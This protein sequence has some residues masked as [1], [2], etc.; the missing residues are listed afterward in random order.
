MIRWQ[1]T[2]TSSATHADV[3]SHEVEVT[4]QTA[5]SAKSARQQHT[6]S[7]KVQEH[8]I[9]NLMPGTQYQVSNV[10]CN[11]PSPKSVKNCLLSSVR[12]QLSKY[13]GNVYIPIEISMGMLLAACNVC[14][15]YMHRL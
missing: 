3:A 15:P 5:T 8:S 2:G 1:P 6:C 11:L 9:A 14:T 4:D 13:H 12:G 10:D 7:G